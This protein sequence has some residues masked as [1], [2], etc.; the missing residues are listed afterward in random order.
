M[1]ICALQR[2]GTYERDVFLTFG[3]DARVLSWQLSMGR[4]RNKIKV[5][6]LRAHLFVP[7]SKT[8]EPL[9][10]LLL[11]SVCE[12]VYSCA[13]SAYLKRTSQSKSPVALSPGL[14]AAHTPST[15]HSRRSPTQHDQARRCIRLSPS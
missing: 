14:H 6:S 4:G 7:S 13:V 10:A 5:R 2:I 9:Q 8:L 15:A 1:E 12:R 11:H 3:V